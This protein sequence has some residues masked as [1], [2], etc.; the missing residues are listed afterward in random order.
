[1]ERRKKRAVTL[2]CAAAQYTQHMNHRTTTRVSLTALLG[3]AVTDAQGQVRGKLKD[4]AVATGADAGQVV[5]LVLKSLDCA[6]AGC[7]G[8]SG[9]NAGTEGAGDAGSFAGPG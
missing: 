8:D 5:G 3:T 6:F 7:A 4:V 1:M 2:T 9:G